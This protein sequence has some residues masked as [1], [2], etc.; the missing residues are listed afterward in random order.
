MGASSSTH[1]I[2]RESSSSGGSNAKE[3]WADILR[4]NLARAK[5]LRM[6]ANADPGAAR[7]RLRLRAWQSARLAASH[8]DLLRSERYS[9]AA[10]FFLNELYGPKDFSSRDEEV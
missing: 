4:N 3:A 1:G 7:D 2:M 9:P 6:T 10:N 8:G 5:A